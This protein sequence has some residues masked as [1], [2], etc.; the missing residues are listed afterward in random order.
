MEAIEIL[1]VNQL[2]ATAS[3][4]G[5]LSL[6]LKTSKAISFNQLENDFKESMD[7]VTI[8][9]ILEAF[10]QKGLLL[11]LTDSKGKSSYVYTQNQQIDTPHFKCSTCNSVVELPQLPDS[12][13]KNVQNHSIHQ[14]HFLAEGTCGECLNEENNEKKDQHK[15][16]Q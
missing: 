6:F 13:L 9:R 12:Y 15:N 10:M 14:I 5:V 3:R 11:K 1:K 4:I 8:Y 16:I 2:K 7:R